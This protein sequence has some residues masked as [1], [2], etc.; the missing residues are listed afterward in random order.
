MILT[1][2]FEHPEELLDIVENLLNT[3]CTSLE[4]KIILKVYLRKV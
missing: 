4:Q 1:Y 3:K 2:E